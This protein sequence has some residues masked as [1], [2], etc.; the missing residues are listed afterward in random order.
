EINIKVRNSG[1]ASAYYCIVM[2]YELNSDDLLAKN[3]HLIVQGL[4][5]WLDVTYGTDY[6]IPPDG[7]ENLLILEKRLDRD[8]LMFSQYVGSF[9]YK[10]QRFEKLSSPAGPGCRS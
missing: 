5:H 4:G 1:T 9:V 6:S 8:G 7:Q 2:D 10:I 3:S